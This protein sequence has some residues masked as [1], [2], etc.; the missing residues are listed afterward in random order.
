MATV[1]GQIL[2]QQAAVLCGAGSEPGVNGRAAIDKWPG[3]CCVVG[4]YC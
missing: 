3:L 4:G 2:V 1:R